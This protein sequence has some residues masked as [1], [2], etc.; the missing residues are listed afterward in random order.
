MDNKAEYLKYL[1][2]S[3]RFIN[4]C[5][6]KNIDV[7]S[8]CQTASIIRSKIIYCKRCREAYDLFIK[9]EKMCSGK[10]LSLLFKY[11][12]FLMIMFFFAALFLVLDAYLKT[13]EA[14]RNPDVA[15]ET[16]K[17]LRKE[18]NTNAFNFGMVPDYTKDFS[19]T[20]SVRWTDMFHI[21]LIQM[22]LMSWCFYFQFTRALQARK[23]LIYVEVRSASDRLNRITS[24]MNLNTVIETTLKVKNNNQMFD[25]FW[26]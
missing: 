17:R 12:L 4:P 21:V 10:L 16:Y 9:Q 7:H 18:R 5:L 24:K 22:I 13:I 26:Y 14:E 1:K 11:F 19:F 23:K 2:I 15:I 3:A 8:Y 20:T 6:C 25:K